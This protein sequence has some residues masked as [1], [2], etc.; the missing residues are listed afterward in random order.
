LHTKVRLAV[1]SF[2]KAFLKLHFSI[3]L[4]TPSRFWSLQVFNE[5][6][7]AVEHVNPG[8]GDEAH[9]L[10]EQGVFDI[11]TLDMITKNNPAQRIALTKLV[12]TLIETSAQELAQSW[13]LL[14]AGDVAPALKLLHTLRGAVGNLGA[15]R[16]AAAT[17]ALESAIRQEAPLPKAQFDV[18]RAE[19]DLTLSFATIWLAHASPNT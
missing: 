9:L 7:M 16:F 14:A 8:A 19:L 15:T 10:K 2:S 6:G 11:A 12:S 5:D 4:S 3:T 18:A 1:Q 13:D 17:C